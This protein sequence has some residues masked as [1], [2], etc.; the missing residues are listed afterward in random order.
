[1]LSAE[2][3]AALKARNYRT[4]RPIIISNYA[5]GVNLMRPSRLGNA[6]KLLNII[7]MVS[8]L[9][10]FYGHWQL[11]ILYIHEIPRIVE[12]VSTMFQTAMSIM[13]MAYCL[14]IQHKFYELLKRACTHQLLQ[15]CEIF[16]SDFPINQELKEKVDEIMSASWTSIR[17]QSLYYVSACIAI[18]CNYFG[19][20]LG[21]N[22]YHYYTR[23]YGSFEIILPFPV[24]YPK[25]QDKCMDFPYYHIEMYL[26]GC[27]LYIA[28]IGAFGFDALFIVLCA[29]GVG[30]IKALC[31]MIE[32]STSP[33]V[34]SERRV[35]YIRY[36]IYQ[37]QRVS[38]Y[39]EEINN[40]FRQ[41][42]L[43]Q[44]LLSLFCWGLVLFQMSL[45]FGSSFITVIR[46]IMYMAAAGYQIVIYCYNGQEFM[47]AS[48]QIPMAFYNCCWYKENREFRQLVRMMIMRTNRMF[49]LDVSWFTKMSL[50]TLM[51]MMKTSGQYF[52]LLQNVSEK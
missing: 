25:W 38:A 13:K 32:C 26:S 9:I 44:F 47:T 3:V 33:L 29:H 23:P 27:A 20:S 52:L 11:I 45:G 40:F 4:I 22:L 15:D 30:Q 50:P 12:T 35:E 24:R 5:L 36:C 21:V 8:S 43:V 37:Y 17:R 6:L 46:M 2:E 39:A 49:N 48:E 7:L 10:S 19:N 1:M 42:I 18:I 31:Y 16:H 34:P 28:G 41:M 14:F 51:V